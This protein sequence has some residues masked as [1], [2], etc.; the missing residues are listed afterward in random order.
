MIIFEKIFQWIYDDTDPDCDHGGREPALLLERPDVP[1][2]GV[3]RLVRLA[4]PAVVPYAVVRPGPRRLGAPV[5]QHAHA[6]FLRP[7]G[8]GVF[9]AALRRAERGYPIYRLLCQRAGRL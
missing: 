1:G 9:R 7:G 4:R 6:I 8:R 3:Q 5:L 2:A